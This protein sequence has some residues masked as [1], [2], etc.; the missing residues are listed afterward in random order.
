MPS[1]YLYFIVVFLR[2]E[3]KIKIDN[4]VFEITKRIKEIDE[5]YYIVFDT[6]KER[7]ELHNKN[8]PYTYCL[9]YPYAD[10]DSRLIDM[11]LYTNINNI[12]NIL[13]DIDKNNN[14]IENNVN[15][16]IKNRSEY[17]VRE[18]YDFASNSSKKCDV[19]LF[20]NEWR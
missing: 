14:N 15:K 20:K 10:L 13:Y 16:D 8:Q 17:M 4:D 7:Y 12:D 19:N 9:T 18:I 2:V 1:T 3:M 6:K 5:G 11:L